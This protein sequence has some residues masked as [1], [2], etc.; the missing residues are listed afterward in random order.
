MG[1]VKKCQIIVPLLNS[2]TFHELH[3]LIFF[4]KCFEVLLP[5]FGNYSGAIDITPIVS[6]S[7]Q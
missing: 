1:T 6:M 3:L 4:L 5:F 2:M 7:I